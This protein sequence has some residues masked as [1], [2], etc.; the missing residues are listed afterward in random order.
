[1]VRIWFTEGKI[2]PSLRKHPLKKLYK[3]AECFA[4]DE[5]A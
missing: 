1:M 3:H 5:S 2:P 4:E